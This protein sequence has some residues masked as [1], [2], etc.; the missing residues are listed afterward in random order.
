MWGPEKKEM[1][2]I[3]K[4]KN[5]HIDTGRSL[6]PRGMLVPSGTISLCGLDVAFSNDTEL[7]NNT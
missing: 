1:L 4:K 5:S 6:A 2:K 7:N 3:L